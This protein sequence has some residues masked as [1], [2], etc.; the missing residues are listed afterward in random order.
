M[1]EQRQPLNPVGNFA[2]KL[3]RRG[4]AKMTAGAAGVM[5][6]G[7]APV[8]PIAPAACRTCSGPCGHC[9][10]TVSH[11]CS[12]NGQVCF[13]ATCNCITLCV[14]ASFRVKETVCDDGGHSRTCSLC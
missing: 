2:T 7:I 6:M 5:T 14:C 11:C 9:S 12:P 3:S 10:S 1:T 13:N 8:I 4:F